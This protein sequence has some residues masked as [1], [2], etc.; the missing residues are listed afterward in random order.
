MLKSHRESAIKEQRG[1]KSKH[2]E[3]DFEKILNKH[4]EGLVIDVSKYARGI[5]TI[6]LS[7]T[8]TVMRSRV[9]VELSAANLS[10]VINT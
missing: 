8:D 7:T 1:G 2:Y 5:Y 4:S 10:I 3:K 9:V 6:E